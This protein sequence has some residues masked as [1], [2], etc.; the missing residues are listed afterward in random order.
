MPPD[1]RPRRGLCL[2]E[3][4]MSP[5]LLRAA[6]AT[7]LAPYDVG[8]SVLPQSLGPPEQQLIWM[9]WPHLADKTSFARRAKW[10]LR[11]ADAPRRDHEREARGPYFAEE[12]VLV[13][14][15]RPR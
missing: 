8:C 5:L 1:I 9:F 10:V 3:K 2:A 15:G 4:A 14:K 12:E 7:H 13:C 11:K 6:P